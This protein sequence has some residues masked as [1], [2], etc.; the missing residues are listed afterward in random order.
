MNREQVFKELQLE[1]H[2]PGVFAG[3]W[4]QGSDGEL[5]VHNPATDEVLGYVGQASEAEYDQVVE[6]SL[7]AFAGW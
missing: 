6:S 1:E 3:R 7:D 4:L 5:T 2:N